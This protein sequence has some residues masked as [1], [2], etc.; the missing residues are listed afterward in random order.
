MS[1]LGHSGPKQV[2]PE[3]AADQDGLV[4]MF[5]IVFPFC[6]VLGSDRWYK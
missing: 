3:T 2:R 6:F 1:E 4:D 5:N